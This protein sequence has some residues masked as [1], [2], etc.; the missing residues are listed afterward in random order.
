[1]RIL[2]ETRG[3]VLWFLLSALCSSILC[4]GRVVEVV[5]HAESYSLKTSHVF[6]GLGVSIECKAET[7]HFT[8]RGTGKLDGN[9]KFTVSM[10]N[11]RNIVRD[12]GTL[13]EDCYAQLHSA[14]ATPCPAVDGLESSKIVFLSKAGDKHV[15]GLRQNLK[16]SP[17]TCVSKF[18]WH[19]PKFNWPPPIKGFHHLFPLPC[20]PKATPPPVKKPCPPKKVLPPP[21]PVYKPPPVKKPCPPKKEVPPPVP[22]YKPPPVVTP[23]PVI[24]KKPCPPIK[25]PVVLPPPIT[26]PKKPCPP[27]PKLPPF[28]PKFGKW[29]PLPPFPSHP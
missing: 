23:P 19:F 3:T 5:G 1:M 29:P 7:G 12:D 16:F 10:N 27:F 28:H 8:T 4:H 14:A 22:V 21:V 15:L 24:P 2:P 13:T 6:S 11:D 26:I 25:P 9:G 18:F 17:E 20:P